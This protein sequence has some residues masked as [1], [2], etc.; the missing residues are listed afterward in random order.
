M[1]SCNV[2]FNIVKETTTTNLMATLSRMYEKPLASNKVHLIT[3]LF[4]FQMRE[5]ASATQHLNELNIVPIEFY[6]NRI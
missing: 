4:N 6:W 3:R 2:A 1:L 5:G